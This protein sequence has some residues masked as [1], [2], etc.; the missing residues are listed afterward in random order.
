MGGAIS[1]AFSGIS[2]AV[3][4]VTQGVSN[5]VTDVAH[6]PLTSMALNAWMPGAGTAL[7]VVNGLTSGGGKTGPTGSPTP[8]AG[9]VG[10]TGAP[11]AERAAG[12]A[13]PFAS[14]RPQYQQQLSDLMSG[15]TQYAD[16]PGAQFA[17]Q[18]GL[19][20]VAAHNR[21]TGHGDSGNE[22]MELAKYATGMAEQGYQQ[23]MS[24]LMTL[25]GATS[26]SPGTAG[27]LIGQ[28]ATADTTAQ[29]TFY[30]T[31]GKD[32]LGLGQSIYGAVT[33]PG[34]TDMTGFQGNNPAPAWSGSAGVMG[35]PSSAAPSTNGFD[36]SLGSGSW[37]ADPNA[38][39]FTF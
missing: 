37:G 14:Q 11:G 19:D 32:L 15:K 18:Q 21:S 22:Q 20:A 2:D 39:L 4:G 28:Q 29:S 30:G 6:S 25:S 12:M 35:P 24:N 7:S 33:G 1:G 10:S 31:A 36:G 34:S 8:Q 38:Q 5:L 13:D 3:S 26:G 23:Q 17:K 9:G 16:T 27:N